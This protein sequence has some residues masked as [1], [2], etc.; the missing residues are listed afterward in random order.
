MPTRFK[1]I[2]VSLVGEI[3]ARKQKADVFLFVPDRKTI[4][5]RP[6]VTSPSARETELL[7]DICAA[8]VKRLMRH[9]LNH[10]VNHRAPLCRRSVFTDYSNDARHT[11]FRG[12]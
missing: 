3:L 12:Q 8:H 1:R 2:D 11:V 10:G 9:A 5:E 6:L 7:I 4:P